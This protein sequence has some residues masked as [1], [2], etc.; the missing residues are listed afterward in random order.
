MELEPEKL[1]QL[2]NSY[3][4]EIRQAHTYL[5]SRGNPNP[6]YL[7]KSTGMRLI[8]LGAGLLSEEDNSKIVTTAK[9]QATKD[10]QVMGLIPTSQ[11][12][13]SSPSL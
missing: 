6:H 3:S 10:R 7:A 2:I 11:P 9:I 13:R 4:E 12:N 8:L 1:N 5:T